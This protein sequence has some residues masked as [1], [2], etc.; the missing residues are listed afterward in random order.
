[1]TDSQLPGVFGDLQPLLEHYGYLAVGGFV[2]LE[3]FGVPV[4]GEA[5]LIA[6]AVFAGSGHMNIAVVILVA[7]LGAIIGDNIGF[8]VGH[9]GGRPLVERFGRYVFLTPERLDH[10][11]Q[12]FNDHGGKVVTI[13]RFIEG[14]RQLNGLLAGIV[15]MHWAKF[16][17]FNAL[18]AVLWVCTW[19]GIGYLAGENIVEIYAAFERYKWYGITAIVVVAAILLTRR[20]RRR[21]AGAGA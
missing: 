11:E 4:P 2:L 5:L 15:G 12:F 7:V 19:A 14:L 21:R 3:D 6:A 13:A 20:V 9:F 16:L 8:V 1:M 10:A 18:G 17:G